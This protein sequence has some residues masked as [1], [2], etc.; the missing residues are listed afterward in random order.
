MFFNNQQQQQQQQNYF[1]R[2]SNPFQIAPAVGG[3]LQRNVSQMPLNPPQ[4]QQHQQYPQQYPQ[5]QPVYTSPISIEQQKI[6]AQKKQEEEKLLYDL[7]VQ[8]VSQQNQELE[9][10][11][12]QV[13]K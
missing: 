6:E 5:Q 2:V 3:F 7:Y 12:E 11:D 1:S 8:S 9:F 4:Q 10:Q 13:Q